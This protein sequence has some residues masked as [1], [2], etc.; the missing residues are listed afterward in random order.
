MGDLSVCYAHTKINNWKKKTR[1]GW[2][3][4]LMYQK[5][6]QGTLEGLG[7]FPQFQ[8]TFKIVQFQNLSVGTIFI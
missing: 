1:I 2:I 6:P 8:Y 7:K 3:Q 4:P 5:S